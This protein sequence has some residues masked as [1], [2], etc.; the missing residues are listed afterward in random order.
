[1]EVL[2]IGLACGFASG[3]SFSRAF[4]ERYGHPPREARRQ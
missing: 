3:T 4:R 2:A 1:M